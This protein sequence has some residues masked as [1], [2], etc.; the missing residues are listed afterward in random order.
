M[1]KVN[2]GSIFLTVG[3]SVVTLVKGMLKASPF[4]MYVG[5]SSTHRQYGLVF[6][7]EYFI[8]L[9]PV[10]KAIGQL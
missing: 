10:M 2:N 7:D 4:F 6:G 8:V 9:D 3:G 5:L 1:I